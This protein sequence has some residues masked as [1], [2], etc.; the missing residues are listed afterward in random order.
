[1]KAACFYGHYEGHALKTES[2]RDA[3]FVFAGG[4][5]GCR[6]DSIFSVQSR[7]NTVN[8]NTISHLVLEAGETL[9]HQADGAQ[10]LVK[11]RSRE[12]RV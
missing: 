3:D 9:I 7:Y 12:I 4:T 10:N 11:S 6:Y 2:S 5:G 1:M 8:D